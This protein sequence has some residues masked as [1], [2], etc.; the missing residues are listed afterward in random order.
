MDKFLLYKEQKW[1]SF[2][3]KYG[4][5]LCDALK[6]WHSLYTD[7]V[8][9]W[10]AGLY[11]ARIGGWYYSES[12]RDNDTVE[13]RAKTYDLLPDVES[14]NQALNFLQ[15]AGM[16]DDFG[17][18]YATAL[19]DWMKKDIG[20]WV[21]NLQ[22]EDGF[23]YHP[24]WNKD[25][26][27][28]RRGRDL[29][30]SRSILKN[31][32]IEPKYASIV[33]KKQT[34]K[35]TNTPAVPEHLSSPERF[36]EYLSTL[37]F[38][39]HSYGVGNALI[40]QAEQIK[41]LGLMDRLIAFL[42]AKQ[43]KE[44]G[45]WHDT[46]GYTA[47]NGLLKISCVY[48][49]A[50]VPFPNATAAAK[51]AIEAITSDEEFFIVCDVYN[52]WFTVDNLAQNLRKYG[53]EEG[54]RQADKMICDLKSVAADGMRASARKLKR[55]KKPGCSFSFLRDYSSEVSQSMPV[56]L[57]QAAEGDVNATLIAVSGTIEKC[58]DALGVS[59]EDRVPIFGRPHFER[60][61]E[62]VTES[63]RKAGN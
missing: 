50:E 5:E 13:Y 4:K 25:I 24:Q 34:A 43:H 39:E 20:S 40:T 44:S 19:P 10:L 8:V 51:S 33:D 3:K 7:E 46:P 61:M 57:Y 2:E 41:A 26:P 14:T 58:M 55:F 15:S 12:A 52:T 42:N 27:V 54:A 1:Q 62:I 32:G 53:G 48:N 29:S 9:E 18:S 35:Q 30:W 38:G 17:A 11:D 59:A 21:Y 16:V 36:D 47:V 37:N 23:Y 63:K 22:D 60:F 31:L 28:H 6:E 56:A 45:Y 49:V